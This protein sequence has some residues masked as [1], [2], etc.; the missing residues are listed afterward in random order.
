MMSCYVTGTSGSDN[1]PGTMA[2]PFKTITHARDVIRQL[3]NTSGEY[4]RTT[5]IMQ[6]VVVIHSSTSVPI[7]LPEGGLVVFVRGG[8]YA[9]V[10]APFTLQGEQDSGKE[11]SPIM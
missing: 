7:G 6:L 1:F 10:D 4:V 8:D 3:K 2:Q 5:A 11:G 9:F